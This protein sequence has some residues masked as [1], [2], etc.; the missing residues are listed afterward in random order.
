[1][2]IS[3]RNSFAVAIALAALTG[4]CGP[5]SG[6]SD[7]GAHGGTGG[8]AGG[9]GGS[10]AMTC[11]V[12]PCGGDVV[13]NWQA[14][15]SC[16]DSASL[17]DQF[18]GSCPGETVTNIHFVPSGTLMFG[19]SGS[20]TAAVTMSATMDLN[21]PPSCLNGATCA[22]V[23]QAEQGIVGMGGIDSVSC[24]GT[25]S[26]TCT[27]HLTVDVENSTGTYTTAGTQLTLT[28]TSGGNGDNGPYC[29]QGSTLHLLGLDMTMPMMG[30]V[31]SDITFMKQ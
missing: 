13:G 30:K 29:V 12:Q 4:A 16:F 26:C 23:N 27:M 10:S 8:G 3:I 21:F 1:M 19:T 6:K 15:S 20:Y 5:S 22:D 7:G 25:S 9:G 31:Q 2:K 24:V 11:S 28:A 17:A 18:A 14:T